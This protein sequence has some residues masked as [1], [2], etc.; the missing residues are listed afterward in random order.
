[1]RKIASEVNNPIPGLS[2]WWLGN[3][4]FAIR[5]DEILMFID[6]AIELKSEEDRTLSEIGLRLLDELP[7][8]AT[9]V[10]SVDI[11]MLTHQHGDHAAPKTLAVLKDKNPLIICPSI[12]LPVLEKIGVPRER[13][14]EVVYGEKIQYKGV[15]IEP[16]RALHGRRHGA[17]S[18]KVELGAGY[19]IRVGG[20]SIFHPGDTVLMEGHYELKDIEI[21][22]LPIC[23]HSRTLIALPEIL[24]PKYIIPMHYGTYEVTEDN[25]FWT[26]GDPE[27][28]KSKIKYPERLVVLRQGEIFRP[29]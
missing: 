24:A 17:V 2:L 9:E 5:Y 12:C 10:E 11:V 16:V 19:V 20:H 8:R 25:R 23:G 1:M 22:L 29:E 13:V 14:R 21:L 15:S 4:G 6:P 7:L 26:Y 27:E 18:P 28:I 3:A